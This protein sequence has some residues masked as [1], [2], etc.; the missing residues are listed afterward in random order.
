MLRSLLFLLLMLPAMTAPALAATVADFRNLGFSPDGRHFAFMEYGVQDGSGFPFANVFVIDL[1]RDAWAG[2]P[3]RI[4]LEEEAADARKAMQI[5]LRK[6]AVTLKRAGIAPLL[7]GR[8]LFHAPPTE[9]PGPAVTAVFTGWPWQQ[10][11]ARWRY[12]LRLSS[13]P[14]P[15][16]D[17]NPQMAEGARGFALDVRAGTAGSDVRLYADR[18]VPA[19]RHC[20]LS[21]AIDR[22]IR[23]E[24]P[25]SMDRDR[26]IR[27]VVIIRYG[28]PAFEGA[29]ERYLAVPLRLPEPS[30]R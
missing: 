28:Y 20:P 21:Y 4:V 22:V 30:A 5:A 24:I 29:D 10:G 23:F 7:T 13:F 16:G 17:C 14:L 11:D 8:E 19:S 26:M 1:E 18:R 9:A 25:G 12:T 6:A 2:P 3:V 27:D 15:G